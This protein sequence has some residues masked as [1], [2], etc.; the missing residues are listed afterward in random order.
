MLVDLEPILVSFWAHLGRLGAEIAN[1]WDALG[2][3]LMI[4]WI[5]RYAVRGTTKTKRVRNQ[6][7]KF[8]KYSD[9]FPKLIFIKA[10]RKSR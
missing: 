7:L 2:Q 3:L 10:V 8:C 4:C 1:I 9:N 6:R 5:R